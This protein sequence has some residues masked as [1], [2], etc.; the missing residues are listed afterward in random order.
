VNH[1]SQPRYYIIFNY[2]LINWNS[3]RTLIRY[4]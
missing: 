3:F 1:E 4:V 2:S